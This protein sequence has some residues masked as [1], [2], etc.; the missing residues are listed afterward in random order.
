MRGKGGKNAKKS[1]K[2][3]SDVKSD[4]QPVLSKYQQRKQDARNGDPIAQAKLEKEI[5]KKKRKKEQKFREKN[6]QQI[7]ENRDE[8]AASAS[9]SHSS[10]GT[11]GKKKKPKMKKTKNNSK[12][13][14]LEAGEVDES[15]YDAGCLDDF[16]INSDKEKIA[17]SDES[18]SESLEAE[19]SRK[20]MSLKRRLS[21]G[22]IKFRMIDGEQPVDFED[23]IAPEEPGNGELAASLQSTLTKIREREHIDRDPVAVN[24][25]FIDLFGDSDQENF[26]K[27]EAGEESDAFDESYNA[28]SQ[29][30]DEFPPWIT[31]IEERD[32]MASCSDTNIVLHYEILAFERLLRPT[33]EEHQSRIEFISVVRTHVNTIWPDAKIHVF[34]S[35]AS[36]LYLPN[37]DIDISILDT[38]NPG[39]KKELHALAKSLRTDQERIRRIEVIGKARIPIIKAESRKNTKE[40]VPIKC[41]ISFGMNNGLFNVSKSIQ[42]QKEFPQL[43]P[44]LVVLKYFLQSKKLN[45]VFSGGLNSYSLMLMIISHIQL[46]RSNFKNGQSNLGGLLLN[47]LDLYGRIFNYFQTGIY[48]TNGGGYFEKFERFPFEPSRPGHL[49]IQDPLDANNELGRNSYNIIHIRECF[50]RAYQTLIRWTAGGSGVFDESTPLKT[51][52]EADPILERRGHKYKNYARFLFSKEWMDMF[53]PWFGRFDDPGL[54]KE[55]EESS[56]VQVIDE[57]SNTGER[58][59]KKKK[60]RITKNSGDHAAVRPDS[61]NPEH[62]TVLLRDE[63]DNS[64]VPIR[65]M[66]DWSEGPETSGSGEVLFRMPESSSRLNLETRALSNVNA[67]KQNRRKEK[68]KV[69]SKLLTKKSN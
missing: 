17:S 46:Y 3:S 44:L 33:V 40:S 64:L 49:C 32:V 42:Y 55:Y 12:N 50:R 37:S 57:S 1:K 27:S 45:E 41:D 30:R 58:Q 48:T 61:I 52:F 43:R 11:S 47:F 62:P 25:D 26:E 65:Q 4:G 51:L 20:R 24:L 38:P 53:E 10:A 2:N 63:Q 19:S 23:A 59:N 6:H 36:G 68:K 5:A 60:R 69:K 7:T 8:T 56:R 9:A 29:N 21:S 31:E 15:M 39:S 13:P 14:V 54:P 34:G 66:N 35:F 28:D 67:T 18:E 22:P 16:L